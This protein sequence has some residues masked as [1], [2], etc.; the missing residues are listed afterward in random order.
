MLIV[1]FYSILFYS[2]FDIYKVEIAESIYIR[3]R[4]SIS[5]RYTNV[6]KQF[7]FFAILK[8]AISYI[9]STISDINETSK[10]QYFSLLLKK[11]NLFILL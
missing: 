11:L 6:S 9:A 4:E 1:I 3:A 8:E 7:S 5:K 2:L 10:G